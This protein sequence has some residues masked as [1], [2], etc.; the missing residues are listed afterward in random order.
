MDC[1]A[2]GLVGPTGMWYIFWPLLSDIKS[3]V[4]FACGSTEYLSKVATSGEGVMVWAMESAMRDTPEPQC[5]S[6]ALLLSFGFD[7]CQA[8]SKH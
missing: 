7:L 4:V 1:G 2:V 3:H 5:V 6:S 8:V